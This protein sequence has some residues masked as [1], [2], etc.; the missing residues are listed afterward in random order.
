MIK[1]TKHAI[2]NIKYTIPQNKYIIKLPIT[3]PQLPNTPNFNL[4]CFL[5]GNFFFNIWGCQNGLE[6]KRQIQSLFPVSLLA[7]SGLRPP[8]L[9]KIIILVDTV[10]CKAIFCVEFCGSQNTLAPKRWQIQ[11]LF[12]VCLLALSGLRPPILI[13]IIRIMIMMIAMFFF[14]IRTGNT[15]LM[16]MVDCQIFLQISLGMVIFWKYLFLLSEKDLFS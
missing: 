3:P 5:R 4:R 13:M 2:S 6:K 12:P 8:I 14:F 15:L 1:G 9:I 10:L 7:L 16:S 11:G